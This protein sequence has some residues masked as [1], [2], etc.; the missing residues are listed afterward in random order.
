GEHG[1]RGVRGIEHLVIARAF[2]EPAHH[3][4][5]KFRVAPNRQGRGGGSAHARKLRE[6]AD[7]G[8]EN[9]LVGKTSRER[10]CAGGAPAAAL[11]GASARR[12][13]PRRGRGELASA[14]T[15]GQNHARRH[16]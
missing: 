10:A 12:T 2:G 5:G 8:K 14:P 3:G 6:R 13:D 15:P 9:V 4:V 11:I 16:L 1:G 7:R